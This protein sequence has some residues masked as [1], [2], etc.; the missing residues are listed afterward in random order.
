MKKVKKILSFL[1]VFCMIL[2]VM[3]MGVYATDL[4]EPGAA[5]DLVSEADP[6]PTPAPETPAADPAGDDP[7]E[8][9]STPTP[10][11][12]E[13]PAGYTIT[14]YSGEAKS[15]SLDTSTFYRIFFLD[16]GRR[17]FS[18]DEIKVII[19][20]LAENNFTHLELAFGN[21][22]L[23]FLL[24]DMSVTVGGTTYSSADVANAINSGNKAYNSSTQYKSYNPSVNEL[25]Q[26]E[27]DTIISYAKDKGIKIIPMLNTPGHMTALVSAMNTLGVASVSGADMS[28]SDS[29]QV[30]FV[31]G[32]LQKYIKYF[33]GWGCECFNMGADEYGFSSLDSTGYASFVSY[34]NGVATMIEDADMVPIAFND[35]IYYKSSDSAFAA[36]AENI[37]KS[38]VI[39]YWAKAE[40]YASAQDL[41]SNGFTLLNNN[42]SWYYV[43]G[44]ALYTAW[45]S[46]G[47]WG[48]EDAKKALQTV[49]CTTLS[50]GVTGVASA[51]CVL[52]L[53]CDYPGFTY[54]AAK[55]TDLIAT[56]AASNP[57][58]FDVNSGETDPDPVEVTEKETITVVAG[59][60]ATATIEGADYSSNIVET[61]LDKSIA[62][63]S[64]KYDQ[65]TGGTEEVKATSITS[66]SSYYIK[67]SSGQYLS[68]SAAWVSDISSAALWTAT[69]SS[70]GY[71]LKNG[72]NYLRYQNSSLTTNSRTATTWSFSNGTFSYTQYSWGGSTTYT[73]GD[74]YTVTTTAPVNATTVTFTAAA[75]AA[76]KTTYVTVGNTRYTINVIAEDLSGAADLPIQLWNTSSPLSVTGVT[77][78]TSDTFWP[79]GSQPAYYASISANDAYG[80]NGVEL[81]TLVPTGIK[82]GAVTTSTDPTAEYSFYKGTVLYKSTTGL[83][84]V[85]Q[86]NISSAEGRVDF[87]YVRYYQGSWAVSADRETWT[88]VTGNGSTDSSSSCTEQ[89]IAYYYQRTQITDQVMTDIVDGG[90]YMKNTTTSTISDWKGIVAL[91]FAVNVNGTQTP[92]SFGIADKTMFFHCRGTGD[93]GSVS[94]Y[95]RLNAI[96]A[97]ETS[98]Y[99]VYMVTIT[100]TTDSGTSF[101]T[102]V[103]PSTYTYSGTER[104][105]WAESEDAIPDGYATIADADYSGNLNYGS[106]I[107]GGEP[108]IDELYIYNLQ[109]MLVTYYVRG[110]QTKD[111]LQVKYV[112]DTTGNTFYTANFPVLVN[113]GE[114]KDF[115]NSLLGTDGNAYVVPDNTTLADNTYY[116]VD[117]YNAKI[118]V[119]TDLTKIPDLHGVYSTGVYAQVKAEIDPNDSKVLILH[120]TYDATASTYKN[121]VV[122]FGLPVTVT[123]N[124]LFENTADI[125]AVT[126]Q[127]DGIYG[128]SEASGTSFTYTPTA[129]L[130]NSDVV[131]ITITYQDKTTSEFKIGFIPATTV[132]YEEGFASYTGSWTGNAGKGNG[133][134]ATQAA[135]SSTDEYGYDAHY[136]SA[137]GASDGTQA[138]SAAIGNSATFTFTGTGVDIYTNSTTETG[139]LFIQVKKGNTTVKMIQVETALKAGANDS[140]ATNFQGVTGYN[141]PVASLELGTRDT[142]TVEIIHMASAVENGTPVGGPVNLDGFRVHG[143]LAP[144]TQ[145]YAD[146]L[147]DNPTFIELRDRVLAS[148]N[149]TSDSSEQYADQIAK[150][151][152][153]QVYATA[154]GE[155]NGAIIISAD[156]G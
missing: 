6:T 53:W 109:G 42:D 98:N 122:D 153:S 47:Q 75:D 48:Y 103:V 65:V 39:A 69:S 20:S 46:N 57:T 88:T 114:V 52:C 27:M 86:D 76:G 101:T 13:E 25:T 60:I 50:G 94:N 115:T 117:P 72:N 78:A 116:I 84:Q 3:P 19:D 28:V 34:I 111:S 148:L 18:V 26:A 66:G 97:T 16:C 74:A 15:V 138:T 135:G 80:I 145:V 17:Y 150:N 120:Y 21:N 54:E 87:T 90:S 125:S 14:P 118:Y 62:T 1:L 143:T 154:D 41:S 29:N 5:D 108:V 44:D 146:D 96:R 99:E 11:P 119:R 155:A 51:G 58:Y 24:D 45:G 83:Q 156:A 55:V 7:A 102:G 43:M 38:I 40:N 93:T 124:D 133:T 128:T 2:T 139:R 9:D 63:V 92:D 132:Y 37:D 136:S 32:L 152:Y 110:K 70:S 121:F 8:T 10:A 68:S 59:G 107:Y 123:A 126:I 105:V 31:Q 131:T 113:T 23:R 33:A 56:M 73:L 100:P 106:V 61:E 144:D 89:V 127:S 134:Q 149:A 142:Y 140:A 4:K 30:A 71:T 82:G 129:V 77:T 130:Q 151:I 35:G 147:E 67:N 49:P 36:A 22:G 81:N 85:W 12:S 64:A 137:V 95:R 104:V 141:V 91:D 112:D 79:Y